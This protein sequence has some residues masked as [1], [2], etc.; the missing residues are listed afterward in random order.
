MASARGIGYTGG[1]KNALK[2]LRIGSVEVDFP[3]VL[4]ALAGYSDVVYR[5]LCR[6]YSAPY[7]ATEAMLDRQVLTAVRRRRNLIRMDA[8]DRPLA[9]QIMGSEPE[10]M[11]EAAQ[12]L[13][14]LGFDVVDLN[15]ACPVRKVISRKRG[16]FMMS[17]PEEILN[18]VRAVVRSVPDR[19]VTLKLR[20]S[21]RA[22]DK[23]DGAFWKIARGAFDAG[24]AAIC[25]HARSVE[26]KY[27]GRADWDFLARV[28]GEFPDRTV[29]GSGDAHSA[30]E[31]LRMISETGVDGVIVARG[32]IGNPWI[33]KQARELAAGREPFHP[34]LPEQRDGVLR[35]YRMACKAYDPIRALKMIRN[36]GIR[37]ARLHPHP[38]KVRAAFIL[39]RT[40][41]DLL[42]LLDTWYTGE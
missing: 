15:F 13:R 11:A 10:V 26:Q 8:E 2:P 22:A 7:C 19:P 24:A 9:G 39:V 38:A 32:A 37:Y 17:R 28:K 4:A 3:V 12:G 29:L 21:F 27:A 33:F 36:F 25:V 23:E 1:V 34:G 41:Q 16:G 42:G 14:E 18:I 20:K 31:A 5:L 30:G 35:H 6:S 40:E